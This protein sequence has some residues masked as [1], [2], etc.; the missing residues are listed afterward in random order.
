MEERITRKI[1]KIVTEEPYVDECH[2]VEGL[3]VYIVKDT[4]GN[5][6]ITLIDAAGQGEGILKVLEE[7]EIYDF[8]K[9]DDEVVFPDDIKLEE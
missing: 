2:T 7:K 3:S 9:E 6:V 4:D 5:E 1:R 8:I